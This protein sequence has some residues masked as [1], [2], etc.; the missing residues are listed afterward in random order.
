MKVYTQGCDLKETI[1]LEADEEYEG[2]ILTNFARPDEPLVV[3]LRKDPSYKHPH[4]EIRKEY[5]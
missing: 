2:E 4:L 5:P 1:F 3:V